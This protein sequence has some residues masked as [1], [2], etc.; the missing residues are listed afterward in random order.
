LSSGQREGFA[1]FALRAWLW[2]VPVGMIVASAVFSVVAALDER[3]GLLAVM[4]VMGVFGLGLLV[5]HF[6]LMY[7]FGQSQGDER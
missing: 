4:V 7:R 2:I 3:W 5:F 1:M 6:W